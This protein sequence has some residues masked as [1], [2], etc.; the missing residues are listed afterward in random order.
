MKD[1]GVVFICK[2]VNVADKGD[3]PIFQLQ[4]VKKFL[5][6]N[7]Y[8]GYGRAYAAQGI[9]QHI[10]RLIRVH[11]DLGIEAGDYA[12][13]GNGEQF[14]IDLVSHGQEVFE[15]TKMVD[16]KY[17]RQPKI[18]GL[19][20]SE[21]TLSKTEDNYD[22]VDMMLSIKQLKYRSNHD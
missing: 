13:L 5:F 21:L 6:E 4:K 10:D 14:R 18:V 1:D 8:L 7:R 20:Y 12:V 22:V 19:K 3:M 17:Y 2:L 11:Q 16:S 15:R 9:N